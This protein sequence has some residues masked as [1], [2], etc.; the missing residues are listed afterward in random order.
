LRDFETW[1]AV[2]K[3]HKA[4]G[5][6]YVMVDSWQGLFDSYRAFAHNKT[7]QRVALHACLSSFTA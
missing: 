1:D 6:R 7:F 4:Q 2:G 3:A 5:V